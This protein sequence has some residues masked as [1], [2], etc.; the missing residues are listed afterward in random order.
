[1]NAKFQEISGER[2]LPYGTRYEVSDLGR[3]RRCV[4]SSGGQAG[5]LLTQCRGGGVRSPYPVVNIV[6]DDG[7]CRTT[8]VHRMVADAFLGPCPDGMEVNHID[9]DKMN[10]R[11]SN[12]EYVTPGGNRTHASKMNL[13]TSGE[14][15]SWSKLDS[16]EVADIRER[17]AAGESIAG[18]A[19][20]YQQVC[21]QHI[22]E[23]ARGKHWREV[24][25]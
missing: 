24:A 16:R 12:L 5:T 20:S 6:C 8:R 14:S 21:V 15:A 2:W 9:G 7:K 11:A 1:M 10:P 4:T 23:I 3:V 13:L 18:I 25:V 22:G 17:Y 19:K